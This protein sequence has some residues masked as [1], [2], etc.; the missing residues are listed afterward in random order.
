MSGTPTAAVVLAAG[1]GTRMRSA[2]PKHFHPVL[3]RRMVDWVILAARS[4]GADPVIA[5]CSPG[6]RRSSPVEGTEVAVQETPRGTGDAVRAAA[7]VLAAFQGDV[8]VLSGDV[9]GLTAELLR[10]I[11]DTHRTSEAS[12]TVCSFIAPDARSYGRIVRDGDDRLARI[13]EAADADPAPKLAH[14]TR[15]TRGIFVYDAAGKPLARA[16]TS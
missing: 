1:L 14:R 3:G 4:A 12:A 7:P 9:P 8:L 10:S 13:V 2:V 6:R 15:S 16:R 11:L 5:V